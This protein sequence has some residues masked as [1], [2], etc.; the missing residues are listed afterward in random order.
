M[1]GFFYTN[2][3]LK[4]KPFDVLLSMDI[5]VLVNS[6]ITEKTMSI[7]NKTQN[8]LSL[9]LQIFSEIIRIQELRYEFKSTFDRTLRKLYKKRV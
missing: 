7:N 1:K 4:P 9:I 5:I 6:L 2:H 8:D 3:S